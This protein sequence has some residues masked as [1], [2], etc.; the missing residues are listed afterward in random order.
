MINHNSILINKVIKKKSKQNSLVVQH[1][2]LI[3]YN[4]RSLRNCFSNRG[5]LVIFDNFDSL[6]R[7]VRRLH[8]V[9][10]LNDNDDEEEVIQE[11]EI[12]RRYKLSLQHLR[13]VFDQVTPGN[14]DTK[15]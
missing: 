12:I 1:I 5:S 15:C 14:G 9:R 2:C 13:F 4:E 7:H 10:K 11:T 8:N 3:C 6:L